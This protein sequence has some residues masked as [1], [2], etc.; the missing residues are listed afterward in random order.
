MY[1]CYVYNENIFI[2]AVNKMY[3]NCI[4]VIQYVY[5]HIFYFIYRI[6]SYKKYLQ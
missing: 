1:N 6:I 4:F 3:K 2:T 5:I